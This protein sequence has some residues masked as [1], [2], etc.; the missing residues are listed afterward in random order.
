MQ[1][2]QS[3]QQSM[4]REIVLVL[5]LASMG[6]ALMAQTEPFDMLTYTPPKGW[7]RSQTTDVVKYTI[8][9]KAKN[10]YCVIGIYA[11]K[12]SAGDALTDFH[13]E[14]NDI[15]VRQLGASANPKTDMSATR[16]GTRV[17]TGSASF[18]NQG[19]DNA[20]LLTLFSGVGRVT[21]VVALTNSLDFQADVQTFLEGVTLLSAAATSTRTP[22]ASSA[23]EPPPG[24]GASSYDDLLFSAPKGWTRA[25]HPGR[26]ELQSP[27]MECSDNSRYKIS[28][29][30]N[31][32]FSGDLKKQAKDTWYELFNPQ[33]Q[34]M[35]RMTTG[36]SPA[37]WEYMTFESFWHNGEIVSQADQSH[38]YG[39]VLLI[40][41]GNQVSV[42][43]LESNH[44]PLASSNSLNCVALKGVWK[45]FVASLKLRN[46]GAASASAEIPEDLL[47]RWESKIAMGVTYYGFSSSRVLAAYTFRDNGYC[48][49]KRLF[50]SDADG[51]FSIKGNLITI[52]SPAGMSET[53]T[54][55]LE[56]EF[57]AGSWSKYLYLTDKNGNESRLMFQGD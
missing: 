55:R 32:Q 51:K 12:P 39:R 28:M 36:T 37:G 25:N 15:V 17:M 4:R 56:S 34:D 45:T 41:Q 52:T 13:S 50:S 35:I 29:Y 54:F 42:I 31:R 1:F 11:S 10:I 3:V 6:K 8:V 43:A 33:Y 44:T 5:A 57:E 48:Q 22:S 21:S 27:D 40:R 2:Q 24:A 38:F 9:D 18:K 23:S 53:F 30:S 7:D 19:V 20:V 14:W 16:D 49:S 46:A 47:G 26:L